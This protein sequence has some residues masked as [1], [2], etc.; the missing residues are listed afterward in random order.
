MAHTFA[1]PFQLLLGV[2]LIPACTPATP[3]APPAAGTA[4]P[5]AIIEA[6]AGGSA[7]TAPSGASGGAANVGGADNTQQKMCGGIA[8]IQCPPQ[9]YCSF[10]PEA[11][12]GA[13]DMSGTCAPVPDVC[14]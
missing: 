12:C 1:R 5:G 11:H 6:P 4:T 13:A 8:G 3:A 14:M 9:Q 10:A 7:A 2:W